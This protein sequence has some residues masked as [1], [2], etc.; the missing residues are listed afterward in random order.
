MTGND[1]LN[2]YWYENDFGILMLRFAS[3]EIVETLIAQ[4]PM[5]DTEEDFKTL[6][7]IFKFQQA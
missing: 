2:I 4:F 7:R 3:I 5:P 6:M 1:F